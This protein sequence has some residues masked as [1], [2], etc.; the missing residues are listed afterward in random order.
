LIGFLYV[1]ETRLLTTPVF[2]YILCF[3]T[4]EREIPDTQCLLQNN[5]GGKEEDGG[6]VE[7]RLAMN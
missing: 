1:I 2:N 4:P 5:K 3:P 6:I 7:S